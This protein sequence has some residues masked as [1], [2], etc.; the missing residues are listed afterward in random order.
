MALPSLSNCPVDCPFSTIW[1]HWSHSSELLWGIWNPYVSDRRP[2][3]PQ[4]STAV[5]HWLR[6]STAIRDLNAT[7]RFRCG[8]NPEGLSLPT[9][10]FDCHPTQKRLV[11]WLGQW[12]VSS[13]MLVI[14][15]LTESWVI[16]INEQQSLQITSRYRM[17]L[18][19]YLLVSKEEN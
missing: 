8:Q 12:F 2:H 9:T 13:G 3:K 18:P 10:N 17:G 6:G 15:T 4:D 14:N 16:K 5:L 1:D 19:M 11:S 7:I